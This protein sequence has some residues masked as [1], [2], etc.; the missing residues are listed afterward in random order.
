M[1]K[2]TL[3]V[4]IIMGC[5]NLSRSQSDIRISKEKYEIIKAIQSLWTID[6]NNNLSYQIIIEDSSQSKDQ[7]YQ[8]SKMFFTL[9]YGD[10]ESVIQIDDKEG[11]LIVGKGY[12]PI[13]TDAKMWHLLRIDIKEGRVRITY[14]YINYYKRDIYGEFDKNFADFWPW[15]EPEYAINQK[16]Y[17]RVLIQMH[18]STIASMV[19]FKDLIKNKS[20]NGIFDGDW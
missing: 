19:E 4:F 9:K 6:D 3:V 13:F 17:T 2:M 12:T 10:G 7:L 5:V 8:K 14:S 11:G 18:E 15:Q 20:D 16:F 1:R